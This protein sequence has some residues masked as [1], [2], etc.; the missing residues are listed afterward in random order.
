MADKPEGKN[1]L[2]SLKFRNRQAVLNFMRNSG[3]VS[4]NDISKAS[5]LSKMTIHKI[6]DYY[7]KKNVVSLVGKGMSTDEGGKK[8]NLFSFNPD[9]RYVFM[10]HLL[11][12]TF[13]VVFTNLK[14]DVV[15]QR[16]GISLMT[17]TFDDFLRLIAK[18]FERGLTDAGQATANCIG[19]VVLCNGIVDV[20]GGECMVIHQRKDWGNNLPVREKLS[21]LLPHVPIFVDTLFRYQAYGEMLAGVPGTRNRFYLMGPQSDLFSGGMVIDGSIY[22]GNTGFSGEV[23]HMVVAPGSKH[24]CRCGGHG[25]LETEVAP[26]RVVAN[27]ESAREKHP[28]SLL[29]RNAGVG[30]VTFD[31]VAAASNRGDAIA[32]GIMDES[33]R[34]FAVAVNN[35]VH[36]CDPGTIVIH[37][38]YA[39]AGKYFMDSLIGA[40]NSLS[41]QG[42]DRRTTIEAS[43]LGIEWSMKGAAYMTTDDWIANRMD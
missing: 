15:E 16:N 22:W 11:D 21:E 26:S 40:F 17:A 3:S 19:V 8:P 43:P 25:C 37:G 24:K 23:G 2:K 18:E 33:A 41:M 38:D 1:S 14:G 12:Q 4:V 42:I 27:A 30:E 9:C 34:H 5:N 13:N 6:V 35:M 7:L 36:S 39:R 20:K 31:D 28:D 29:F 10:V 32:C